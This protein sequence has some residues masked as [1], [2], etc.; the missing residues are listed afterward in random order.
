MGEQS[1]KHLRGRA[2][3]DVIFNGSESA[4]AHGMAEVTLTFDNSTPTP[5]SAAPRVPRLRRDRRHAP[6]LPR[7][8]ER[9]PDQQD[10]GPPQGHHRSVPRHRRRHQGVLDHRAG[11]DRP[12]RLGRPE[13]R[14]MLIEEAAGI[15]KYKARKKQAEQKMELTRQNL[16]RVGDIVAEIERSLASLKRQAAKAERYVNYKARARGP[17]LHEAAHKLLEII[18]RHQGRGGR[19]AELTEKVK[20]A[21]RARRARGRAGGRPRQ[22][23]RAPRS[24]PKPRRRRVRRRQ[25]G[26]HARDGD[27]PRARRLRTSTSGAAAAQREQVDLE[28]TPRRADRRARPA[29]GPAR[30]RGRRREREGELAMEEHERLEELRAGER[31]RERR[32]QL[33]IRA[34]AGPAAA[35]SRRRGDAARLRAA[36]RRDEPAPREARG[37]AGA[38]RRTRSRTSSGASDAR[39]DVVELAEGKRISAE[40]GHAPRRRDEGAARALAVSKTRGRAVQERARAEAQPPARAGGAALAPRGRR[41]RRPNAPQVGDTSLLGLVADRIEA[42]AELTHAFAGLLGERLQCIVTTDRS[43]ASPCSH[44]LARRS[45]GARR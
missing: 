34:G 22:A 17:H 11:Q 10:P 27:Q 7:R 26:A 38:P 18:A 39:V 29:R 4:R 13:D 16:L 2:M 9:V 31:S 19:R 41:R 15:T 33:R 28:R 42:P 1:A 30:I 8:H 6:P 3:T 43:G 37:R 12:H 20:A 36:P 5:R 44:D 40:R 25:R 23:H 45:A 32:G 21:G 35:A 14:R 24:R